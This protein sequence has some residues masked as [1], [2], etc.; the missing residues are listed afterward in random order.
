MCYGTEDFPLGPILKSFINIKDIVKRFGA[1]TL[2]DGLSM[3]IEPNDRLA[4]IGPNGVGKS[5]LLKIIAGSEIADSGALSC[6]RDLR[7]SY[8]SQ[9]EAF[10][11]NRSVLSICMQSASD[12]GVIESDVL[13]VAHGAL[14]AMGL[15]DPELQTGAM[16]G[17]QK[18]RL[19]I[20]VGLSEEPD[21]LLLDEPT[22]HLDIESIIELEAFLRRSSFAWVVISHDRWFLENAVSR[23]IEI[24]P[25]FPNYV[26]GI[27]GGY[28]DYLEKR[29][30]FLSSE[31]KSQ[32]SLENKVRTEQAW[33]RQGAKAR[34]TKSKKRTRDAYGMMNSLKLVRS[35]LKERQVQL[36][37]TSSDRRTKKLAEFFNVSKSF[38][39]KCVFEGLDLKLLA[40]EAIGV[41]GKNGSGKST[42][43]KLLAGDL[44][45]DTGTIKLADGLE[46][47]HF[48]QFSEA[49]EERVTLKE[50]LAPD[51]DGVVYQG[52]EVHVV[53]WA[54]RFD[55]SFEQLQQPFSRLSGGEK[56]RARIARLMLET[57][58][59]LILDEP[60]NDL[61][62]ATLEMLEQSLTDFKGALVLVSHDRFMINRVCD[63]FLGLD[64][65]GGVEIYADYEQWEREV[66]GATASKESQTKAKKER[67]AA[68]KLSYKEQREL[69]MM[70]ESIAQA[71]QEM[72]QF[73]AQISAEIDPSKLQAISESLAEVQARVENMYSR[74]Q[75]LEDKQ[76]SIN[77]K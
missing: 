40:G 9:T 5:T 2:F 24:N 10:V 74:W 39:D 6:Q 65:C 67:G 37:F 34:S 56:A 14:A 31:S 42:I 45:P 55:F 52:K 43:V 32:N 72:D 44:K 60:T 41:L 4:I 75:E 76:K 49:V 33:L 77:D 20:A 59:I 62:I 17:G 11:E 36:E 66:L 46:I 73:Q 64:S 61:D 16:S 68:K 57:P 1:Q 51:S 71:E 13:R 23:I 35:R 30:L 28:S 48:R 58:D 12:A 29:S 54:R 3:S 63:R 38:E 18:K 25:A 7:V 53:S 70:E 8:V 26:L 21:V 22:N 47:S 15:H 27:D 19:Q 69:N 50:Y